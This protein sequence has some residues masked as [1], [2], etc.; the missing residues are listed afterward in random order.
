MKILTEYTLNY[1]KK[2]RKNTILIVIIISIA[3]IFLSTIVLITYMNWDYEIDKTILENGNYHGTFK[4]SINKSQIPYL[5]ENQKV[6]KVYLKSEYLTGSMDDMERPYINISYMDKGYWDNMGEKNLI[7]EGRVPNN[8][9]EIVVMG[10]LIKENPLYEVGSKVTIDLGYRE[11]DGEK[12]D[13]FDFLHPDE[14]FIKEN[15]KEYTIVGIISGK[16]LSYEPYYNGLGFLD[17]GFIDEDME[18]YAFLRM[19]NPRSVYKDLPE[20]GKTLGFEQGEETYSE[21]LYGTRYNT[22]YLSLQGIFPPS[23]SILTQKSNSIFVAFT[24]IFLIVFMFSIIIYNVFAIWSNN[25]LRQLGIFKSVGATP[26]QIKKTVKIE[27]IYLSIV[28]IILGVGLGHVF[29]YYFI[30]K[31]KDIVNSNTDGSIINITFKTSPIIILIILLLSFI[32]ILLSISRTA[33]RLSKVSPIDAIKQGGLNYENFRRKKDN[34]LDYNHTNIISSLSKDFLKANKKS[35]RTTIISIGI[36]FTI[37]FTFLIVM[38]GV[39]ADELLNN[40]EI[41]YPLRIHFYSNEIVDESLFK[42]ISEIS[43]VKE[44]LVYKRSHLLFK[45]KPEYE[46][47][48]FNKVGGFKDIDSRKFSVRPVESYYEVAGQIIGIDTDNFNQ[49]AKSLGLNPIEYYN[50]E[51]PKGILI[52]LVK[53]DMDKPI[54]RANFIP[55]LNDDIDILSFREYGDEGYATNIDI[56]FKTSEKPWED[57]YLVNYD[58]NLIVPKEVLNTMMEEFNLPGDYSHMEY[59]SLLVDEEDIE[60]VKDEIKDIAKY[61]IPESD[62][63]IWDKITYEIENKNSMKAMYLMAFSFILFM[64]VIGISNS[65]SSINNNLRS[66]RREFAM[67]KSMGMTKDGLKKMLKVEGMYYSI[68]PFIYSIPLCLVILI[69]MVKTNRLFGIRDFLLYLDYK[70]MFVYMIIIILSIYSAYYF[71]IRKIEK[72]DIVDI[73]RDESI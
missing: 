16:S 39:K 7:L 61:Y 24:F 18:L 3:V 47:G 6:D 62:Y 9:D 51:R 37:L 38:S 2:N 68:Y 10:S 26:K 25:R 36:S 4:S 66:R 71:G 14:S 15:A 41:H 73:L 49:Y 1:L 32:T 59:V 11:K 52:N 34:E 19:K 65:Y 8:E 60:H 44:T 20:I 54:S 30:E 42:E 29:C 69:G 21:Y 43:E 46:S 17:N 40:L 5:E 48:E 33:K 64:G 56:G 57:F 35:F 55:Y 31:I 23:I 53:E 12:V 63:A 28:P 22:R 13:V 45:I 27:A 67:L 72:E 58:I 50:M 70:I